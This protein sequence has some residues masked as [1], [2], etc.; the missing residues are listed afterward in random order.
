MRAYLQL[1]GFGVVL[2][3]WA[4]TR[5]HCHPCTTLSTSLQLQ[6]PYKI[7]IPGCLSVSQD[8]SGP[9]SKHM[10][11]RDIDIRLN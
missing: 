9:N 10:P 2:S 7:Y 3:L 6:T 11:T 1:E 8:N 4:D 5:S